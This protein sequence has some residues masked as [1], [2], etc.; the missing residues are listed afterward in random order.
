MR[1][2]QLSQRKKSHIDQVKVALCQAKERGEKL[3]NK[4]VQS[5]DRVRV[6][7][8]TM[9]QT[10]ASLKIQLEQKRER[11]AEYKKKMEALKQ[12]MGNSEKALKMLKEI[13]KEVDCERV[14]ANEIGQI[15]EQCQEQRNVACE[16][17]ARK[18]QLNQLLANRQDKLA[19]LS[20]QHQSKMK[21]A[22][23][24]AEQINEEKDILKH[25]HDK[26]NAK[27]TATQLQKQKIIETVETKKRDYDQMTESVMNLYYEIIE[28][29]DKYHTDIAQ[30]WE[31]YRQTMKKH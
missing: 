29:I 11:L 24:T 12:G 13:H 23:E 14:L 28:K 5:P 26:D 15:I 30:N 3:S 20:I 1:L 6:E 18:E 19:K 4:I 16:L 8:E 22:S 10:L 27:K 7:Q 17:Q 31:D 25:R 9:K 2:K 21:A